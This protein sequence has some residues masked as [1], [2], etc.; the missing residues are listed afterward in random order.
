MYNWSI[1]I[2]NQVGIFYQSI[3]SI[4][5]TILIKTS[6]YVYSPVRDRPSVIKS[7]NHPYC[8][9]SAFPIK[10]RLP[11][12]ASRVLKI[13]HVGPFPLTLPRTVF[14]RHNGLFSIVRS[15]ARTLW[16]LCLSALCFRL[17]NSQLCSPDKQLI[18][19]CPHTTWYIYLSN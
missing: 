14:S 16:L 9:I 10:Q 5:F 8:Y 12:L 17:Y 11:S 6:L 2:L 1:N 13:Q 4:K 7:L 18:P 3:L 15:L 19:L